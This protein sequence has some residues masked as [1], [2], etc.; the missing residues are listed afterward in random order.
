MKRIILCTDGTWNKPDQRDKVSGKRKPSNVVII[1][2][3]VLP[4]TSDGIHQIVFYDEGVGTGWYFADQFLGGAFG[5][6]ISKNI[7]DTYRFLVNNYNEGDEVFLFGFSRGAFTA[8]SVVGLIRKCGLLPKDEAF[9]I[10][11]AYEL[12]RRSDIKPDSEVARD[13][14]AKHHSR[15]IKIKFIGVWDTVGA[16][17]IPLG[18]LRTLTRRFHQFH[19]VTL[20]RIVENAYQALAIDERRKDFIPSLWETQG[21]PGQTVQQ[22]WFTGVHSNIGGG[23]TDGGLSN[24]ALKWMK[25]RAVENGLVVDEEYLSHFHPNHLGTLRDS[26][27]GFWKFR[28]AISRDIG[29]GT[30]SNESVHRSVLNRMDAILPPKDGR[31][32]PENLRI[33]LERTSQMEKRQEEID[34][35][36]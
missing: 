31:Y 24:I 1:S 16:L 34:V 14:I 17:G 21:I 2:R 8:R 9:F 29:C 18:I 28:G 27:T 35:T 25:N 36:T 11:D 4:L 7:R 15:E 3:A 32:L 26:R 5:V 13:F 19:D 30:N 10:E 12:Y 23:Y 33:Y 6:G 20:S 22:V